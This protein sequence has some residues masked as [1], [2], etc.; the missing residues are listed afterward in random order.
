[1]ISL[2][3]NFP[4]LAAIILTP[5]LIAVLIYSLRFYLHLAARLDKGLRKKFSCVFAALDSD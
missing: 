3:D 5:V 4:I 1:M 2:P